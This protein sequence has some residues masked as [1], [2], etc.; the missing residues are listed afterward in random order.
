MSDIN[1]EDFDVFV[2]ARKEGYGARVQF[3]DG[4]VGSQTFPNPCTVEELASFRAEVR[5][6][7]APRSTA[8]GNGGADGGAIHQMKAVRE[9]GQKLFDAL[10][11][12]SV[13]DQYKARYREAV[14]TNSGIRVRLE[15]G[16]APEL[17]VLPWELL[18]DKDLYQFLALSEKTPV[19]RY[20]GVS[21]PVRPLQVTAPLRVL[22]VAPQPHG[23]EALNVYEE[24]SN[25]E[26]AMAGLQEDGRVELQPLEAPT[27]RALREQ[28]SGDR[29]YHVLHFIGH[30]DF[31]PDAD[32]AHLA[33]EQ[34]DGSEDLVDGETLTDI[35]HNHESLR[36]VVL[37]SCEAAE[38]S[39]SNP[40]AG[41]AQSLVRKETPAVVAMQSV[42]SDDSAVEFS[43]S[44]YRAIGAGRPIEAA[45]AMGRMAIRSQVSVLEWATPV[46]YTRLAEG[47]LFEITEVSPENRQL[48]RDKASL[49]KLWVPRA[50]VDEPAA[51]ALVFGMWDEVLSDQGEKDPVV[52]LPYALMLGELR[53]FLQMHYGD[54][55]LS[56]HE[57]APGHDGPVVYLGGPVTIPRVGEVV[58]DAQVPLWFVGLPYAP[59]AKRCI[60]KPG[61]SY[62]PELNDEGR[63]VADVGVALRIDDGQRLAFVV[64]GCYG[65]GTLG[66]ARLLMDPNQVRDLGDLREAPR[67]EILV[68]ATASGW[69]VSAVDVLA[70]T[71]W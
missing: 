46:F 60:G 6:A 22:V 52:A 16:E 2:Y 70:A 59:E 66:A 49:A 35:L 68:R 56:K 18:F 62:E 7:R 50:A 44:F 51:I 43:E 13:R 57:P 32:E 67:L 1:Y 55:V 40:F 64:A 63:V 61:V 14:G 42:I 65:A 28:L 38:T 8:P 37:N 36:L 9:L 53:Q 26:T 11:R 48:L 17:A 24:W 27:V 15:L 12:E 10:F 69:D 54:V 33:F 29:D 3:P 71:A 45:V 30:G 23:T 47:T 39:P 21:V 5:S 58:E 20:L 34:E 41:L 31:D 19:V 25:L 4:S